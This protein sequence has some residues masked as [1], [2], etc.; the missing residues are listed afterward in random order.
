MPGHLKCN[1]CGGVYPDTTAPGNV[2]Y[3][4]ACPPQIVLTPEVTDVTHAITAPV[5][6]QPTPNP[7]N[8]TLIPDPANPGRYK[9][10][11][12]GSGVTPV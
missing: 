3:F 4:H 7:R 10:L 2:A 12:P 8:E 9:I 11:S 6:F 5:V 1:S